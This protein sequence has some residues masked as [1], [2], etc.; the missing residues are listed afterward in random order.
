M[1]SF[2]KIT[3]LAGISALSL[4]VAAGAMAQEV[5]TWVH[6]EANP[7][8]VR[9]FE[10]IAAGYEALHPEVDIQMQYLENEAYKARLPTMLQ[11]NDAPDIF[12]SWGG[13]VL[14]EQVRGGVLRAI[15]DQVDEEWK[16]WI[17]PSAFGA[18]TV[19]GDIYGVPVRTSLVGFFYNKKMFEQAGVTEADVQT[20]SGLLDAVEKLKAEGFV[21]LAMGG[22]EG[23][24]QHFFFSYLAIR[25]AGH[26]KLNAALAGEGEGFRDPAFVEAF[27]LLVDLSEMDPWQPGWQASSAS[28]TYA[29]IGNG[30]AAMLLQGDWANGLI[31][32]ESA[33]GEGLG[34]DLGWF[35][36]P[37]VEGGIANS[38]ETFGGV[39]GWI[40]FKDAS[41]TAVDFMRY[42]SQPENLVKLANEGGQIA[43]MPGMADQLTDP[44]RQRVA[45]GI[46]ESAF[47][48]NFYNVMFTEE[49]NR[50]LLDIVT[51]VVTG[52][53]TAEEAADALQTAWE[54]SR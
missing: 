39:N 50:E 25:T 8:T 11:S 3:S 46:E 6:I 37:Q 10:E 14:A 21:P 36:F 31:R 28:Q 29:D 48:Q 51:N 35:P 27:Q 34:D 13:G 4:M 17:A 53:F 7:D 18:F 12:Y 33:S 22:Q 44:W 19:D 54:F 43:P 42:Y 47:H 26:E 41:D 15:T 49:V 40:F 2:K 24:P 38:R 16:S 30:K 32:N 45:R 1:P 5:V 23:W 20:W 9:V 52:D